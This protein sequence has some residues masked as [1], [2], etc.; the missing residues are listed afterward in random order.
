MQLKDIYYVHDTP[1][2]GLAA[3]LH[4]GLS[5][6]GKTALLE[7]MP[8][9]DLPE[10]LVQAGTDRQGRTV[11]G[12]WIREADPRLIARLVESFLS[13]NNLPA[14]SYEIRI[15]PNRGRLVLI[16]FLFKRGLY[17]AARC[18]LAR[19]GRLSIRH[20]VAAPGID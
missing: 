4:T 5:D 11:Y 20:L 10:H 1:L 14:D 9:L 15:V 6:G 13:I 8:F 18:L 16:A 7:R 2:A 12:L 3:H 19:W 17:R